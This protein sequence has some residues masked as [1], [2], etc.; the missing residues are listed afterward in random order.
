VRGWGGGHSQGMAIS[1][2]LC[3]CAAGETLVNAVS[4]LSCPLPPFPACCCLLLLCCCLL[5]L[6]YYSLL[7]AALLLPRCC[8]QAPQHQLLQEVDGALRSEYV[9]RRRMLI[10]RFKVGPMLRCPNPQ[11]PIMPCAQALLLGLSCCS[12]PHRV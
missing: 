12:Y 11:S 4:A 8:P 2:G 3:R 5:L 1:T 6:C 7:P 9:V 10:E